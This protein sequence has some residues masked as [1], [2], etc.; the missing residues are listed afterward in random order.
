V[1][2]IVF[3]HLGAAPGNATQA[4]KAPPADESRAAPAA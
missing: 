1:L 3:H 4:A 2:N